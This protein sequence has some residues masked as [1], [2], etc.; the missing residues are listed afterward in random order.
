MNVYSIEEAKNKYPDLV[1]QGYE[2]V[3]TYKEIGL[4][5][6]RW[7]KNGSYYNTEEFFDISHSCSCPV[8]NLAENDGFII[9]HNCICEICGDEIEYPVNKDKGNKKDKPE[10]FVEK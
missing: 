5:I 1:N 10:N 2:P 7:Y 9:A 4:N 3:Q 8:C 6:V